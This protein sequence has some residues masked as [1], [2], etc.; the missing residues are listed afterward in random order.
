MSELT[1]TLPL[2]PK[3]LSPNHRSRSHWP[4]TRATKRYRAIACDLALIAA[5]QRND[6]PWGRVRVQP[7]FYFA[8][9]R[10]RDG[11]NFNTALKPAIDALQRDRST[12]RAAKP[13]AHIVVNDKHVTLLPPV[14]EVDKLNPRVELRITQLESEADHE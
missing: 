4:R 7:T 2:P 1:L 10:G 5:R 13:G 8:E 9:E 14:F 12:A 3:E 11:D 6:L